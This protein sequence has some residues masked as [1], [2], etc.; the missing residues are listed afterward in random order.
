LDT[1]GIATPTL[2][3]L[4]HVP[5]HPTQNGRVGH[6]DAA[7]GDHLDKISIAEPIRQVPAY[8]QLY[9]FGLESA[10]PIDWVAGDGFG[11]LAFS[12]KTEF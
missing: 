12:Q 9:D 5:L 3:E 6:G 11:H 1:P 4:G 7:L 2:L 10:T 8:A